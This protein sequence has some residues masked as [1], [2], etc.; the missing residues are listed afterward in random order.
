MS[1][2]DERHGRGGVGGI[3][4]RRPREGIERGFPKGD[5][6]FAG[7]EDPKMKLR[8]LPPLIKK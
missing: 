6:R 3:Q 4:K 5:G 7:G 2:K 1:E 8:K